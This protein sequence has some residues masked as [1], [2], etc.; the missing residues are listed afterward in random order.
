[1][2]G[3]LDFLDTLTSQLGDVAGRA[4]DAAGAVA[5]AKI[6]QEQQRAVIGDTSAVPYT[7][8]LQTAQ[9]GFVVTP[10]MLFAG[11]ALVG[12]LVLVLRK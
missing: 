12:V 1:V 7:S 8:P 9:A 4:V 11:V 10:M 5:T 2:A 6:E 3:A